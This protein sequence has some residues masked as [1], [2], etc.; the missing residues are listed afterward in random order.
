MGPFECASRIARLPLRAKNQ[1]GRL[2][3]NCQR[4]QQLETVKCQ[5]VE[6]CEFYAFFKL[7]G[8]HSLTCLWRS[9]VQSYVIQRFGGG[10]PS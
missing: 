2:A 6:R 3:A 5:G 9:D 7:T 1:T 4:L 8:Y 10:M